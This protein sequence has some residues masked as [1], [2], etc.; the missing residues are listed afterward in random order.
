MISFVK[1][2]RIFLVFRSDSKLIRSSPYSILISICFQFNQLI[3]YLRIDRRRDVFVNL[4]ENKFHIPLRQI[5]H[6]KKVTK[7][8]KKKEKK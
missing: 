2:K 5:I 1:I 8:N 7:L 3:N 4:I 6:Q